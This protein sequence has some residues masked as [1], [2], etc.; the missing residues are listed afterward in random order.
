MR[1]TLQDQIRALDEL[2]T[3]SRSEAVHR[4][5]VAPMTAPAAAVE[6]SPA[7]LAPSR[8]APAVRTAAAVG[9][10]DGIAARPP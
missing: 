2:S 1:R 8:A 3:L 10:L 5:I 7:P 4:D 6:A 9:R